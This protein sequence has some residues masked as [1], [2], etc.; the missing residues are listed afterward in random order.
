MELRRI[1]NQATIIAFPIMKNDG[2][3]ISRAGI[4]SV[5]WGVPMAI[6]AG[7]GVGI[8]LDKQP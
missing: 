3:L 1:K 4:S 5:G 7:I 6:G 2:T 8:S